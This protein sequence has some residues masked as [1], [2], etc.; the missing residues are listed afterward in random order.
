MMQITESRNHAAVKVSKGGGKNVRV[1]TAK[2]VFM[3]LL[4]I[5]MVFPLY[6]SLITAL[7]SRELVNTYPPVFFSREFSLENFSYIFNNGNTMIMLR[8]S[9]L[10]STV[11]TLLSIILA[12]LAA[13]TLSRFQFRGKNLFN[14]LILCPMLIPGITNMIPLYSAYSKIGWLNTPWGLILLYL[15]GLLPLPITILRNYMSSIP[16]AL[17]EAAMIDGCSR[18]KLLVKVVLPLLSPGILAVGLINFI[19]VWNEFLITLIFTTQENM[20]T[21]TLGLYSIMSMVSVHKGVI[22]ATAIVSLVPVV[23]LFLV[24]R[25]RFINSMLDGAVKG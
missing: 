3:I 25:K 24:F 14:I 23:L 15:P 21:M 17:E 20:K 8:N 9:F 7:K 5:F 1:K 11:A 13:Y 10:F 12:G 19:S 2:Q 22:N 4:T 6:W 18:G 16:L